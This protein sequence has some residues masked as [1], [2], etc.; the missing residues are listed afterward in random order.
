[1]AVHFRWDKTEQTRVWLAT[2]NSQVAEI[3]VERYEDAPLTERIRH[4]R[5]ITGVRWP[6]AHPFDIVTRPP[7]VDRDLPPDAS[8]KQNPHRPV[9]ANTA[10]WYSFD[11]A[12]YA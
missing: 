2:T 8:I 10:A 1:M 7:K 4:D 9:S 6:I 11:T 5:W 12:W 3:L